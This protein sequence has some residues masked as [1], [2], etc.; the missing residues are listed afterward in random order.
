MENP[1]AFKRLILYARQYR[2][3]QDIQETLERLVALAKKN[4]LD[5]FLDE[6]LPEHFSLPCPTIAR[7]KINA[8]GDLIVVVGGDG[9]MLSAARIAIDAGAPVIGVNRGRLGFLTD[10]PPQE[11]LKKN[12]LAVLSGDYREEERFLL[13]MRLED[14]A[15]PRSTL[16]EPTLALNDVVLNRRSDAHLIIFDVYINDQFVSHYR[17]D[18]LIVSTPTGSTAY[19]L[20]AGGP[21]MHPRLNAI[22]LVP[23]FSHSLS[24]RPLVID[25]DSNI[26]IQISRHNENDM[27]INCD[28]HDTSHIEPDQK[29][30]IS[31]YQKRLRLLHP[32]DYHYYDTLRKKLSWG[33][34]TIE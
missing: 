17:A 23:M 30:F 18:G 9:S 8:E 12:L 2:A 19:A 27:Q 15:H 5:V 20:S 31:K 33:S 11:N 13:E 14:K 32:S 22:V 4:K 6:S 34:S 29:I 21:I 16:R 1:T 26:H 7:D 28:G 10:L 24:S 3:N 25:G